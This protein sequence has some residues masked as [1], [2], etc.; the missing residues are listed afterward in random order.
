MEKEI[1]TSERYKVSDQYYVDVREEVAGTGERDYWLC[2]RQKDR[3][4]FMYTKQY[5]GQR[6]EEDFLADHI[7]NYIARY[8][9][10]GKH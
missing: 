2:S 5:R 6:Q 10:N 7:S 3:K 8:E 9:T 1:I 4:M